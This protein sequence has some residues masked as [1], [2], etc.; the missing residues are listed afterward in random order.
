MF[1]HRAYHCR[2]TV[3]VLFSRGERIFESRSLLPG[4]AKIL[5]FEKVPVNYSFPDSVQIVNM[6]Q[7]DVPAGENQVV[8]M[9]GTLPHFMD[10]SLRKK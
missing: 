1:G 5:P 10:S 4:H 8:Y 3:L 2:I 7:T 6:R 9:P